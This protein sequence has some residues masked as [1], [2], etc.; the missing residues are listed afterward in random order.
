MTGH[1]K[2]HQQVI[3]MLI[4]DGYRGPIRHIKKIDVIRERRQSKTYLAYAK[5]LC[6][7]FKEDYERY[8]CCKENKSRIGVTKKAFQILVEDLSFY[9]NLPKNNLIGL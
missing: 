2:L 4:E 8:M 1:E 5:D 3:E 6:N 9:T 7:W